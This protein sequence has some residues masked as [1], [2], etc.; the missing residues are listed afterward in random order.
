MIEE[1]NDLPPLERMRAE[2]EYMRLKLMAERGAQIH[3]SEGDSPALTAEHNRFLR[4]VLAFEEENGQF[5][6]V[7]FG[8]VYAIQSEFCPEQDVP[9]DMME[10]AWGKME[11]WL[12]K[13]G[14]VVVAKSPRVR[15]A[16]LYR[17]VREELVELPILTP[18]PSGTLMCFFYDDF[19]PDPEHQACCFAVH[20]GIVPILA[21]TT[22]PP[23]ERFYEPALEL[24]GK[25]CG[26]A[27]EFE[28]R[29]QA[30]RE[31][32]DDIAPQTL[33]AFAADVQETEAS[34]RGDLDATAH[35]RTETISLR[36]GWEVKLL[37]QH[38]QDQ[39]MIRS[40]NFDGWTI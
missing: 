25:R 3:L 36:T 20:A 16:D 38:P 22:F 14:V 30:F 9:D 34:F 10:A 12:L 21:G 13:M 31:L 2:N 11:A 28:Q 8:Q 26:S 18:T 17:F 33:R 35:T 37:R 23:P 19:H 7:P 32:F 15:P 27:A 6:T 24:S 39:W 1:F 4:T 29:V 5:Y 40:V